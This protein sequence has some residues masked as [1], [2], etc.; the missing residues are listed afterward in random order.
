MWLGPKSDTHVD[1]A[2]ELNPSSGFAWKLKG[3][4]QLKTPSMF[5]GDPEE[6]V[7]SLQQSVSHFEKDF[8][9][10][11]WLYLDALA[12]LGQSHFEIEETDLARKVYLKALI[13]EPQFAWVKNALLPATN[14]L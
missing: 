13:L 2:L 3:A 8:T 9:P 14:K 10:H 12:W 4:A 5:G 11:N 7:L 6:A 1:R